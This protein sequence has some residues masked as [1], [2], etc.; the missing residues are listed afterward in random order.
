MKVEKRY[1]N[2]DD[3]ELFS[4]ISSYMK[5]KLDIEDVKSDPFFN[6]AMDSVKEMLSD[7]NR[8]ISENKNTK[9]NGEFIRKSI[10]QTDNKEIQE[11]KRIREIN[12]IIIEKGRSDISILTADWVR[13]WHKKKQME[14]ATDPKAEERKE[15]ITASLKSEPAEAEEEIKVVRKKSIR[16]TIFIRYISLSAA[17]IIGAVILIGSLLPSSDPEKLF[18][19]YYTTFDAILPT[20]RGITNEADALY[21]SALKSYKSGDFRAAEAGFAKIDAKDLSE[22]SPTF[23][24]G[25]TCIELGKYNEAINYLSS[26]A[27]GSDDNVKEAGWYLGLVYLKTSDVGRASEC[28]QTLAI[29][30]GFYSER[31]EKLLRRLK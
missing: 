1:R 21:T 16:K 6:S 10:E 18:D 19:S 24:L 15:F 25:L 2:A 9:E 28:F 29:S 23:L 11:P 31:S 22:G 4:E 5:A 7:Y 3:N 17:A 20:T 26:A 8:T 13:E 27:S 12:E 14:V 30:P